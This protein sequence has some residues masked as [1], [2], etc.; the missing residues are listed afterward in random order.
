MKVVLDVSAAIE[1][2][3]DRDHADLYKQQIEK[4]SKVFSPDLFYSEFANVLWKYVHLGKLDCD[5]AGNILESGL[6]LVDDYTKS[7][8]IIV[9]AMFAAIHQG[10]TVYDMLYYT[11]ARRTN[12]TLL[13]RDQKLLKLAKDSNIPA[14]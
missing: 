6:E 5:V 2:I 12:A 7:S 14:L 10:H 1:I 8:E 13:T 4:A 11:I 3:F 9:E